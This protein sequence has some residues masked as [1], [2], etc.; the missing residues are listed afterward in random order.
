MSGVYDIVSAR[1]LANAQAWLETV[2]PKGRR[3]GREWCVAGLHGE[4]GQSLKINIDSGKWQDFATGEKGGDLIALY[5]ALRQIDQHEA[6]EQLG[7]EDELRGLRRDR[8]VPTQ[9]PNTK[10][11]P[12]LVPPPPDT[13]IRPAE[14]QHPEHGEPAHVYRY[15]STDAS[16]IHLVARY[17]LPEGGKT[18]L[19]WSWNKNVQRWRPKGYPK[20]RPLYGLERLSAGKGRVL[21]VEGE[22]ACEAARALMPGNAV[23]TW[24]G[25]ANNWSYADWAPLREREVVLWPDADPPGVAAMQGISGVLLKLKCKV[26]HIDP[27]GLADGFD[28]ADLKDQLAGGGPRPIDWIK[29]RLIHVEHVQD[30]PKEPQRVRELSDESH[31]VDPSQ[32]SS[33]RP[34]DLKRFGVEMNKRGVIN[35]AGNVWRILEGLIDV[36]EL[37]PVWFDSFLQRRLSTRGPWTDED[38]DALVIKLNNNYGLHNLS[39][40]N[41][42]KGINHY[43]QLHARN[44][45]REWLTHVQ[46]DGV[47]RLQYLVS[48]G[49]G[50]GFDEYTAAV[51]RCFLVG[52]A[53]RVFR[54]GCQMDNIVVFEGPQGARKSQ[55]LRALGGEWHCEV[56]QDVRNKD[57]YLSL[58]GKLLVEVAE[59]HSFSRADDKAIKG[60]ITNPVDRY[61][62]PYGRSVEDHPRQCVFVATTNDY[63]WNTDPTGARR[64]WPIR[65]GEINVEWIESHREQLFAE[66]VARLHRGEKWWDVP[67]DVAREEQRKRQ[68]LDSIAGDMRHYLTTKSFVT[69]AQCMTEAL[70]LEKSQKYDSAITQRVL[71]LLRRWGWTEGTFTDDG[72]RVWE[73]FHAPPAAR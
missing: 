41:V 21:V 3:Q 58:Q 33:T 20:P 44:C 10:P 61:R 13:Q 47:E 48:D 43:A 53:A 5:A 71:S 64:Y 55:A 35:S 45:A 70:G 34:W 14:L 32:P 25:G 28:A 36:G 1:L 23:L 69:L 49:F 38:D 30:A 50:A 66:A 72:G 26:W 8:F 42:R 39:P 18:F 11:E 54:P 22:K 57:F 7:G 6:L 60:A 16:L 24:S 17:E 12:F 51:G 27:E 67:E 56:H 9:K 46:W 31:N 37:H 40:E 59:L 4:P 15:C 65:C 19:P 52:M 62:S 63:R 29:P 68:N 73:G 2:L